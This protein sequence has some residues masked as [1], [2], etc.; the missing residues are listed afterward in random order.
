MGNA[1]NAGNVGNVGIVGNV[2]KAGNVGNA[3]NADV[4]KER[5][6]VGQG[7]DD[8]SVPDASSPGSSQ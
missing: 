7:R 8:M 6:W 1:G 2:G 4:W 5:A 3:G